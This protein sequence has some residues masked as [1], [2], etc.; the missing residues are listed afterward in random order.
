YAPSRFHFAAPEVN[1]FGVRTFTPGL[2]RSSQVLM[3]FGLPLRTMN[4]TSEVVTK[5]LLGVSAQFEST[6]P[7]LTRR[8]MSGA[9]ENDTTSAFRPAST[10]RL[11]S[12]EAPK[13]DLK[14]TPSPAPVF[15]NS[16]SIS[17]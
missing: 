1:G 16:G 7:A 13:E 10:A 14:P 4:E 2:R 17:S 3:P 6:R 11:C 9:R 12:P 8:S 15:W 5:P